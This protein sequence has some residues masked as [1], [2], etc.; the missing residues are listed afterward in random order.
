MP[1]ILLVDDDPDI[2]RILTAAFE[3]AGHEVR[4]IPD[5]CEVAPLVGQSRFDAV[6]LDVMMPRR[7]GWEVLED[8]RGNPR[9]ERL[10]VLM[11]SAIGDPVNRVRGIR[12]GADD[13]LAKPFH[14]EEILAR[15]EGMLERRRVETQ[16]LVGDFASFP[17]EA[18]LQSLTAGEASG[19]LEVRTPADDGCVRFVAGRCVGASFAGF[20][21]VDAIL[22]LVGEKA[23]SFRLRTETGPSGPPETELPSLQAVMLEAAWIEDELKARRPLLPPGDRG[24]HLAGWTVPLP[25][26]DLPQVPFRAVLSLLSE[27][28][29]S[30]LGE[31]LAA[32]LAAPNRVRLAVACLIEAGMVYEEGSDLLDAPPPAEDGELPELVAELRR[33][34]GL[35]GFPI[36]PVEVLVLV[37]PGAAAEAVPVLAAAPG[38]L[39][40]EVR[41]LSREPE[42][43]A[44]RRATAVVACLD[45]QGGEEAGRAAAGILGQADPRAFLL[46]IA[47]GKPGAGLRARWMQQAPRELGSLLLALLSPLVAGEG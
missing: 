40:L 23:G 18:V 25:A 43:E 21:G 15:I 35:R 16:G 10:P 28:P 33:E 38:G 8:L 20:T 12:L 36:D 45:G 29:G 46:W 44:L 39:R 7:S 41:T 11:L 47:P 32:R 19:L 2:L 14:P 27:R 17:A 9:T 4:A 13:F 34:S 26:G 3:S 24:L 30:L 37:G 6:V 31:I 22:A 5:P 42:P 1:N